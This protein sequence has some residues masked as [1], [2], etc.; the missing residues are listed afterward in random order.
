MP[1][2]KKNHLLLL[3]EIQPEEKRSE[4]KIIVKYLLERRENVTQQVEKER[5]SVLCER[6]NISS[7]SS[8]KAYGCSPFLIC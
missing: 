8:L 5:G 7:S 1:Y 6:D 4:R 3:P 2:G